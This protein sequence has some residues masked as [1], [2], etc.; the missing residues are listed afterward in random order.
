MI[1]R[2]VLRLRVA[3]DRPVGVLAARL[4]DVRPDGAAHRVALGLLNLAH[5]DGSERP[6]PMPPGEP[7]TVEIA[8]DACAYRFRAGHRLRLALSTAYF[9]MVLPPPAAATATIAT[10]EGAWLDLP[11]PE[12]EV[13]EVPP[14]TGPDP[15]PG[16][17][18]GEGA[19]D[20]RRIL[21][22]AD[23][24]GVSV[25]IEADTGEVEHPE[26]EMRWRETRRSDW[27]VRADD[28]LSLRGEERVT[29]LRRRDGVTT[30]AKATGALTATATHW[31]VEASVEAREEGRIVF[32]RAWRRDIPRDHM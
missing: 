2:P 8:L 19:A 13:L 24:E 25:E 12:V 26:N 29:A 28:P 16:W 6:R 32:S 15:L 30:E 10:G 22:D 3:L 23:G 31:R 7:E 4:V 5:R 21:R 17:A 11:A 14:P 9:P 1:G 18:A 20:A 27:A